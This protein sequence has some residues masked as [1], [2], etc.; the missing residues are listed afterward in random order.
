MLLLYLLQHEWKGLSRAKRKNAKNF[1]TKV[2]KNV[3]EKVAKS[4]FNLMNLN[5]TLKKL[6]G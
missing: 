3:L 4:I 5:F 1:S 6:H 2:D